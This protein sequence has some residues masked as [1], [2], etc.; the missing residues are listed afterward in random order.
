MWYCVHG[1]TAVPWIPFSSLPADLAHLLT[2]VASGIGTPAWFF[3][4]L[5]QG[6]ALQ[7][8]ATCSSTNLYST[9]IHAG[10]KAGF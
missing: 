5:I 10:F 4:A 6:V 1:E 3:N 7:R 2:S 8:E 9:L